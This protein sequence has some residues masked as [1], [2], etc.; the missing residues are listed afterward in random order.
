MTRLLRWVSSGLVLL[1]LALGLWAG[2]AIRQGAVLADR[3]QAE[4]QAGD[5]DAALIDLKAALRWQPHDPALWRQRSVALGQL[6][7]F[8][9]SGA[10]R[11]EA[12]TA[13]RRALA[14]GANDARNAATLGWALAD[15][16]SWAE[17]ASAFRAAVRLDPYNQSDLYALALARE[18]AG[19]RLP[20]L[21]AYRAAWAV[22]PDPLI[23]D[24]LTRL[25]ASP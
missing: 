14:N 23:R 18:L 10:A 4:A 24:G 21:E 20:A 5:L 11:H 12:V 13:A 22:M 16:G 3:A 8:R 9:R 25:G 6:A 17:A 7:H 2:V 1:A 15:A 19:Q